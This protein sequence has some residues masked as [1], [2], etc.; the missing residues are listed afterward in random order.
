MPLSVLRGSLLLVREE[1]DDSKEKDGDKNRK[2]QDKEKK[3]KKIFLTEALPIELTLSSIPI[4]PD[5]GEAGK[6]TVLGIDSNE[7]GVRDDVERYIVFAHPQSEKTR[8]ALTQYATEEQKML[9][10]ANDKEK[11]IANSELSLRAYRCFKFIYKQDIDAAIDMRKL[12]DAEMLNTKE[13][14]KVYLHADGQLGG[15]GGSGFS[16]EENK[17]ACYV[18]PDTLAN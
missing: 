5:P 18:N 9:A 2:Q 6:Q 10:D 13:R 15:Q 16:D 7:N 11:T 8:M 14:S 1:D 4:P 3:S 12:L 17:A